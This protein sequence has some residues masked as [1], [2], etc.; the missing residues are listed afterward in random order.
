MCIAVVSV[1]INKP[2]GIV[3]NASSVI[4]SEYPP[5]FPRR[6]S[7]LVNNVNIR[8]C[9]SCTNSCLEG[10]KKEEKVVSSVGYSTSVR[11]LVSSSS[12]NSCYTPYLKLVKVRLRSS[13]TGVVRKIRLDEMCE[14]RV[15]VER[16]RDLRYMRD[17]AIPT[18]QPETPLRLTARGPRVDGRGSAVCEETFR[19]RGAVVR[20][21]D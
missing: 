3:V 20:R 15:H 16:T 13:N 21:Q 18:L 6:Q 11:L 19:W 8:K 2:F 12:L 5:C 1:F 17:I 4:T 14:L 9:Y 10:K 7:P